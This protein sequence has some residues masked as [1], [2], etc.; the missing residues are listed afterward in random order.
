MKQ[1][2]G[3]AALS[4]A[5][6]AAQGE[7]KSIPKDSTNPHF[8]NRYC[9]L[10]AIT[11]AVRPTLTKHGLALLQGTTPISDETGTVTA[12][13]L[14]TMLV[15]SSGEWI[16]NGVTMPLDKATPQ[17][18]GSAITY[19][20]RYGLSSLLALT[21]DEDDDGHAASAPARPDTRSNKSSADKVMP[22][23]KTKGKKL[24]DLT[25]AELKNAIEWCKKTDAAKFADLIGSM[26][27][28]L[29]DRGMPEKL[30]DEL[31]QEDSKNLPFD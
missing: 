7:V 25:D 30:Y 8:R 17:G 22:F 28:V 1:S 24:G 19:G 16:S 9:S 4:K 15:H 26:A 2:L 5:L 11:E 27:E 14:E 21:T 6:V 20:R 31:L 10:E 23:G 29:A 13:T 3:I 12:I 18:V